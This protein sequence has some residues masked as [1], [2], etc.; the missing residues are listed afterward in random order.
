VE[1]RLKSKVVEYRFDDRE[2]VLE[3]GEIVNGDLVVA[4]DGINSFARRSLLG[5]VSPKSCSNH[6]TGRSSGCSR[7]LFNDAS[8]RVLEC[9]LGWT[10]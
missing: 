4:V 3:E 7:S 5:S 10:L 1:I 9:W 6:S 8:C 2:V